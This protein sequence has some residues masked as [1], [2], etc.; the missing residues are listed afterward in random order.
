M[1]SFTESL[2]LLLLLV[3]F[4][5][6]IV[7]LGCCVASGPPS[8]HELGPWLLRAP[9]RLPGCVLVAAW[10]RLAFQGYHLLLLPLLLLLLLLLVVVVV[11][12]VVVWLLLLLGM[13]VVVVLFVV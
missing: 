5:F 11:V 1:W 4:L 6:D 10:P 2:L 8:K 7:C 9:A 12:V 13:V 3:L